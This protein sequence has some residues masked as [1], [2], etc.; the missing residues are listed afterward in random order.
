MFESEQEG[1]KMARKAAGKARGSNEGGR[2]FPELNRN[3]ALIGGLAAAAAAGLGYL[4]GRRFWRSDSDEAAGPAAASGN[5]RSAGA[6][7]M[8]DPP[9]HWDKV[10]EASDESFPASDPPAVKHID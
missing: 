8:R 5:V 6:E 2:R 7:A 10:D 1:K 3:N 4:V 9:K